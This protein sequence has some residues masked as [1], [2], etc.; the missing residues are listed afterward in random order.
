M[1]VPRIRVNSARA[2]GSVIAVK[3]WLISLKRWLGSADM[4]VRMASSTCTGIFLPYIRVDARDFSP[5][6]ISTDSGGGPPVNRA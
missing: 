6:M 5:S 1:S 4:A 3:N 2:A